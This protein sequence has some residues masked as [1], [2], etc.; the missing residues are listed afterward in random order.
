MIRP[1]QLQD[2]QRVRYLLRESYLAMLPT[3]FDATN[4]NHS[5]M[6]EMMLRSADGSADQI[7]AEVD[8]P[9]LDRWTWVLTSTEHDLHD[10]TKSVCGLDLPLKSTTSDL[11]ESIE[12]THQVVVGMVALILPYAWE[13]GWNTPAELMRMAV[14]PHVRSKG[15]GITLMNTLLQHAKSLGVAHVHLT[16][17]NV[18]AKEFYEKKAGFIVANEMEFMPGRSVFTLVHHLNF[19][20]IEKVLLV[21]GTHG[22]ERLGIALAKEYKSSKTSFQFQALLANPQAIEKN[23]RYTSQDLNRCITHPINPIT[24]TETQIAHDLDQQFGPKQS[25][26]SRTFV[27]DVHSTTS[28][29]GVMLMING[30][31]P[32]ALRLAAYLKSLPSNAFWTHEGQDEPGKSVLR[33]YQSPGTRFTSPSIDSLT[34][35]GVSIEIG[36]LAH[37]TLDW[38]HMQTCRHLVAAIQDYIETSNLF[39][40]SLMGESIRGIVERSDND[41]VK[42]GWPT[43]GMVL[44]YVRSPGGVDYPRSSE[45]KLETKELYPKTVY[46]MDDIT[47]ALHPNFQGRDFVPM[48]PNQPI[49]RSLF[50]TCASLLK[51][52][53][54]EIVN[55]ESFIVTK[56]TPPLEPPSF[57]PGTQTWFPVF[58]GEQSYAEKGIAFVLT[59]CEPKVAI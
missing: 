24:D 19:A 11:E 20:V 22:N 27:I 33:I 58:I 50:P 32:F 34:P 3:P 36:P 26:D 38:Q 44:V 35:S 45:E 55:G 4:E 31:D 40:K 2:M 59:K 14:C 13:T 42:E 54:V 52:E 23:Q 7:K 41:L 10:T 6:A 5:K 46:S 1:V 39:V 17:A 12:T 28:N 8:N 43:K 37:G 57:R 49:F 25:G 47:A 16:T 53:S 51:D 56:W 30:N 21:G 9:P 29:V 18:R 48:E 15:Y